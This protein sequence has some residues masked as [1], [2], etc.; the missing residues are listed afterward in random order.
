MR[1]AGAVSCVTRGCGYGR[2]P[3]HSHL[4]L[5]AAVTAAIPAACCRSSS[6]SSTPPLSALQHSIRC[7]SQQANRWLDKLRYGAESAPSLG[8]WEN[9]Y[10]DNAMGTR[11][12]YCKALVCASGGGRM[13]R[14]WIAGCAALTSPDPSLIYTALQHNATEADVEELREH[15]LIRLLAREEGEKRDDGRRQH[16]HQQQQQGSEGVRDGL[17]RRSGV[18]TEKHASGGA[19]PVAR[20]AE[21]NSKVEREVLRDG[22]E[23]DAEEGLPS[24]AGASTST[25]QTATTVSR[26]EEELH[27]DGDDESGEQDGDN[28]VA[29]ISPESIREAEH[30]LLRRSPEVRCFMYDAMTASLFHSNAD[31]RAVEMARRHTFWI[32]ANVF[33]ISFD[34]L[35]LLWRLVEAELLLKKE[36]IKVLGQ[37]WSE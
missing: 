34:E 23:A 28:A 37:P 14:D 2:P 30:L 22:E 36:K 31:L 27:N 29:S 7:L 26:Q 35:T 9:A 1:P 15:F 13:A 24:A 33:G 18:W 3:P 10:E 11:K 20:A 19:A 16:R 6:A 12:L 8:S 32:G 25:D 4:R 17:V 5:S 21:E